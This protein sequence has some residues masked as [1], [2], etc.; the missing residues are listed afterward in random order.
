MFPWFHL[1]IVGII[2][3]AFEDFWMEQIGDAEDAISEKLRELK[4]GEQLATS[5]LVKGARRGQ[6]RRHPHHSRARADQASRSVTPFMRIE[7][8]ISRGDIHLTGTTR[9]SGSRN[10]GR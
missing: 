7:V 1:L 4:A 2:W 8:V 3:K 5:P 6:C 10:G 9:P